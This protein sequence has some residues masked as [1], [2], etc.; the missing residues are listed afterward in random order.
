MHCYQIVSQVSLRLRSGT[1]PKLLS[2]F[3]SLL[4]LFA[5]AIAPGLDET[6]I[7]EEVVGIAAATN[8]VAAT[9]TTTTRTTTTTTTDEVTTTLYLTLVDAAA[10]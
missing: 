7:V 2:E 10:I 6:A 8:L 3:L 9:T 1:E 4:T 5:L